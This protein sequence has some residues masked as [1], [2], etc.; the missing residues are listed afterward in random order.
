MP[1]YYFNVYDGLTLLDDEGTELTDINAARM[2]AL[3]VAQGLIESAARRSEL[4]QSW[5][6]EVVNE[7]G[8]L[9]FRMDF[10]V[11]E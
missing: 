7:T 6:V 9:L 11:P 5:R 4:G 1:R 3:Q 10:L 8:K 2:E